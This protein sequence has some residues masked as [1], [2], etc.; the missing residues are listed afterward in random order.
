M[1]LISLLIGVAGLILAI[2]SLF[3]RSRANVIRYQI[4]SSQ[5]L[6]TDNASIIDG[7]EVRVHNEIVDE[8]SVTK[9]IVWNDGTSAIRMADLTTKDPLR[10]ESIEGDI[11]S[12]SVEAVEIPANDVKLNRDSEGLKLKF[13]YLNAASGFRVSVLHSGK[14]YSVKL[15]G[16]VQ[17]VQAIRRRDLFTTNWIRHLN[18]SWSIDPFYWFMLLVSLVWLFGGLALIIR[19]EIIAAASELNIVLPE[20]FA[21]EGKRKLLLGLGALLSGILIL[22]TS[23]SRYN[24]PN[25]NPSLRDK[26]FKR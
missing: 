1:N 17:G 8:V 21:A 18:R 5:L 16:Q 3:W 11:L 12:S 15:T 6:S 4:S 14:P 22:H 20:N 7:L 13:A 19:P 2:I 23:I 9:F 10:F 24:P 25:Y 26:M